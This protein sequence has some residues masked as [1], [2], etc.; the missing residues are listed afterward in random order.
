MAGAGSAIKAPEQAGSL[1]HQGSRWKSRAGR[2]WPSPPLNSLSVTLDLP[3]SHG[4]HHKPSKERSRQGTHGSGP[5][6]GRKPNLK[7]KT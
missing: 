2:H 7:E 4:G 3:T 5:A 1:G 6:L